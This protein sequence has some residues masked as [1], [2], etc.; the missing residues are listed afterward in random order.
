MAI[1][2]RSDPRR[3]C[4]ANHLDL[5]W[6]RQIADRLNLDK[7]KEVES[8]SRRSRWEENSFEVV[9]EPGSGTQATDGATE[10]LVPLDEVFDLVREIVR[11]NRGGQAFAERSPER[12]RRPRLAG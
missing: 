5:A 3:G 4:A 10:L 8:R 1:V 12:G 2:R 9:A 7:I 6:L 11:R